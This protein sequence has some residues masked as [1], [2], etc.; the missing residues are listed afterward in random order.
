MS[1]ARNPPSTR[2]DC[3]CIVRRLQDAGCTLK[4]LPDG[5]VRLRGPGDPP[6]PIPPDL[7]TEARQHRDDIAKLL[8]ETA[9]EAPRATRPGALA[10]DPPAPVVD[11]KASRTLVILELAGV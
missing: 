3:T 6:Q 8:S 5:R 7:I 1:A 2:Q 10:G 4:L 11:P 9:G